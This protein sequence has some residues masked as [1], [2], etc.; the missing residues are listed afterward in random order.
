MRTS[1]ILLSTVLLAGC[2]SSKTTPPLTA[3]QART[4][5]AQLAND[6]ADALYHHRPFQ[7]TQPAHY[8]AGRWVWTDGHGVGLLDYEAKVELAANGSSNNVDIRVLDDTLRPRGGGFGPGQ[9]PR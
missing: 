7:N 1:L 4:L 3:E 9:P 5:S 8:E 6:K 2:E